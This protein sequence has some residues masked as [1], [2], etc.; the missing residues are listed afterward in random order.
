[1]FHP[2]T[3]TAHCDSMLLCERMLLCGVL[4]GIDVSLSSMGV[5]IYEFHEFMELFTYLL[6]VHHCEYCVS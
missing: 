4:A 3:I 5:S 1:M 6:R 2:E